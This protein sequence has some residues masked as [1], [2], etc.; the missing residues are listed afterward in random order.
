MQMDSLNRFQLQT[1]KKLANRNTKLYCCPSGLPLPE[2]DVIESQ[3]TGDFN[4]I[5]ILV[6]LGMLTDVSSKPEHQA[7]IEE[8]TAIEGRDIV[9]TRLS[10]LGQV[11]FE[12][13]KWEKW[14]N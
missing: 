2:R 6:E 10:A 9:I 14:R 1:L 11:M 12:K 4:D 7:K 8:L 5:L 13:V 3:I